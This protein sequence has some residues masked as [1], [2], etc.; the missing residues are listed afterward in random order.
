MS[1]FIAYINYQS[2]VAA[3]M[4][5]LVLVLFNGSR[6]KA[7]RFEMSNAM[8]VLI[9]LVF[10]LP[11]VESYSLNSDVHCNIHALQSKKHLCARAVIQIAIKYL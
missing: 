8:K 7:K 10:I 1:A 2:V 11:F 6:S 5:I 4:M 3:F 9:V